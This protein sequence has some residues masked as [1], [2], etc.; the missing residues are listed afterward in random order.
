MNTTRLLIAAVALA[1]LGGVVWWSNRKEEANKDKPKPET[2]K[3]LGA[4]KKR[5]FDETPTSTSNAVRT[6]EDSTR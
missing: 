2:P 6:E 3:I 4:H 1:G 5:A